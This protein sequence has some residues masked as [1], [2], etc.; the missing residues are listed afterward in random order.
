M[1][2]RRKGKQMTQSQLGARVG[3]SQN[4]ISLIESGQLEGSSFIL[5]ICKV[6]RIPVPMHFTTKEQERWAL[7]GELLA[8]S[9]PKEF[10]ATIGLL[11]LRFADQLQQIEDED[12]EPRAVRPAASLTLSVP[13]KRDARPLRAAEELPFEAAERKKKK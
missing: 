13:Q 10:E 1:V 11:E 8:E 6:L 3:T 7:L 9:S 5:K 4:V 12:P 2:A